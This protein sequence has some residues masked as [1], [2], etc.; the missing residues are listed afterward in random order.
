MSFLQYAGHVL[1]VI[2]FGVNQKQIVKQKICGLVKEEFLVIVFGFYH[3]FHGFLSHFLRY[4]VDAFGKKPGHIRV[5]GSCLFAQAYDIF[6]VNKKII[7]MVPFRPAG[8]RAGMAN[9]SLRPCLDQ[10]GVLVAI[11]R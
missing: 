3:Q 11:N 4:F 7:A 6:Q 2:S 1:Q 5:V 9:R 8:I 10:Q